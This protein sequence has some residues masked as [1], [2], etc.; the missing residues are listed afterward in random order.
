M[1][2]EQNQEYIS[3]FIDGELPSAAET[4][5]F[6]HL[7]VCE[8]CRAFLKNALSLRDALAHTQH[9]NVPTSLDQRIFAQHSTAT[10]RPVN[11]NFIRHIT[12]NKYSF[13]A[14]GLAAIISVLTGVLFT[15]FWHKLHQSQ[16]TIV[17]LTPLPEVEITGYVVIGHPQIKGQQQ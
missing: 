15:S 13:R 4:E 1:N 8:Q 11:Q 12:K 17:C 2:C 14:I 6:I 16:Q 5:L 3:Q 10:K 7:G 9:I